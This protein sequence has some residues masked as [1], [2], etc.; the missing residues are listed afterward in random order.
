MGKFTI[1]TVLKKYIPLNCLMAL[2]SGSLFLNASYSYGQCTRVYDV[3]DAPSSQLTIEGVTV[4]YSQ[5][6]VG[7]GILGTNSGEQLS[8]TDFTTI[9]TSS[10][11]SVD[12]NSVANGF[13]SYLYQRLEFGQAIEVGNV[14]GFTDI[15][16]AAG[17]RE[18]AMVV[19]YNANTSTRVNPTY[20]N[21]ATNGVVLSMRNFD[22]GN[23]PGVPSATGTFNQ[24]II[25][26]ANGI[27]DIPND[28]PRGQFS[29]D[30][31]TSTI[32]SL[33]FV[34]G[35][36]SN[37][38][39]GAGTTQLSGISDLCIETTPT[40][41]ALLACPAA[42]SC[43]GTTITSGQ[44]SST[45][46]PLVINTVDNQVT[47]T[48]ITDGLGSDNNGVGYRLGTTT[49][50]TDRTYTLT[51]AQPI[52]QVNLELGFINN[53]AG[54]TA[55][56]DGEEE[57]T[58][59]ST[60]S[61]GTD[62]IGYTD[63]GL[64][65]SVTFS[66]CN[67][68]TRIFA[69]R[70]IDSKDPQS[71][72]DLSITS[73]SS[74]TQVTF[75]YDYIFNGGID[76]N[77]FGIII[78]E[79]C[80]ITVDPC[81]ALASGNL[82][83]DGDNVS[84]ICDIDDDNDGILDIIENARN[85][86]S[87]LDGVVDGSLEGALNVAW[88]ESTNTFS[89]NSTVGGT[90]WNTA[91]GSPD[92]WQGSFSLSGAGF[93]SGALNGVP[94][95]PDGQVFMA[96]YNGFTDE[97]TSTEIPESA[98]VEVGDVIRIE[99]IQVFGG[100]N[101][102]TPLNA[103]AR[104]RWTIDGVPYLA[105]LL[106]YNG[107]NPK[108]WE[109]DFIEFTATTT[110]PDIVLD[111]VPSSTNDGNYLAI[112]GIDVQNVTKQSCLPEADDDRDGIPNSL[113]LDSDG[114]GCPD[115]VE[116]GLPLSNADLVSASVT[117]GNGVDATANTTT[118]IAN[119]QLDI[120]GTDS[121]PEDGLNDSLDANGDGLP[122]YTSTYLQIALS[123][124]LDGCADFDNDGIGDLA[125]IDD[126]N[127]GIVDAEESPS[128][129]FTEAEAATIL[130]MTSGFAPQ[131]G[132]SLDLLFDGNTTLTF[133]FTN[134]QTVNVG[135][136]WFTL[137]LT[138]PIELETVVVSN[139]FATSGT[140]NLW[141]SHDNSNFVQLTSSA[142][143][144]S[145]ATPTT[146]ITFV[147]DQNAD[148][149]KYYQIRA[150]TAATTSN[151][152]AIAEI[153]VTVKLDTYVA[154]KSF[155]TSCTEDLD[156]DGELNHLDL[157][158]DGDG[159]PDLV[160]AGVPLSNGDIVSASVTNG[161]GTDAMANTT[162]TID[163][164][165]LDPSGTD[166]TPEDGLNDSVDTDGNGEPDYTS[167]YS[168]FALDGSTDACLDSDLDGVVD[169][170]DIDD[171]ND[172]ILDIDEGLSSM[173][174][175]PCQLNNIRLFT[176]FPFT[177][178]N[179]VQLS[180]ITDFT[181]TTSWPA[182]TS[183]GLSIPAGGTNVSPGNR[184]DN[185]SIVF[186]KPVT[187]SIFM[188]LN[189]THSDEIWDFFVDNGSLQ[190]LEEVNNGCLSVSGNR[191]T[192]SIA[193]GNG[194]S[195]LFEFVLD[196]ASRLDV[197]SVSGGTGT[198]FA[199]HDC[200]ESIVPESSEDTDNDGI[201]NHLDLDSDGDGCPDS[202]EAGLPLTNGD[203]GTADVE[204][205]SGGAVTSTVN[206]AN[207][208]LDPNATDS[209]PEDGLNDSVDTNGDGVPDYIS[210]YSLIALSNTLDGC[211]DF[212]NDGIGDLA[213]IDDDNDGIVDAE[214]SPSCF[215]SEA[216]FNAGDR[217]SLVT[218][219]TELAMNA[220]YNAPEEVVDGVVGTA[221]AQYAVRFNNQALSGQEIYKFEFLQAVAIDDIFIEYIN[222]NS[223]FS[224]AI[225]RIEGSNDN[226]NWTPLSNDITYITSSDP[227]PITGNS[228]SDQLEITQNRG[229]YK[230]YRL[231]GISGNIS[232]NGNSTEVNFV[233]DSFVASKYFKATCTEDLDSDGVLNHRDLDSD[234][235][236]CPDAEEAGVMPTTGIGNGNVENGDGTTN[237]IVSTANA[238]FTFISNAT[239]DSNSDGIL[240]S[241]DD[242][243]G[244][245][246]VDQITEYASTYSFVG[247]SSFLDA[248]LDTDNDDIIDLIDIDDDND[249]VVDAE[250]SPGCFYLEEEFNE[251]DR[252]T[253]VT[254]TTELNMIATY[255]APEELVDSDVGTAAANY[256]VQFVNAQ[257]LSGQEVYKFEFI[258]PIRV[259]DIFIEYVNTNSHFSNA[260]IR[261]EGSNNDMTWTALSA[262]VTYVTS[263]D[264]NPI[265]GNSRSD[266]LEITQ[267]Q[268]DY[269]YY[270]LFGI[271]GTISSNGLSS[272]VNFVFDDYIASKYPKGLCIEDADGDGIFNHLDLDSDG[273]GCP[274]AVEANVMPTTGIGT[275]A[276]ENGSGGMV[277]ST[278]SN[279]D[280]AQFTFDSTTNGG[281]DDT[282][283]DGL[284]DTIDSNDGATLPLDSKV[285]YTS[286]YEENALNVFIDACLDTDDDGIADIFDIDDDNDG[287]ID[288][289]EGLQCPS[290][291]ATCTEIDPIY[292]G[293]QWT[294]FNTT[295]NTAVGT[296][297]NHRG[298]TITVNY[299][300]DVRNLL[301]NAAI[302]DTS[303]HC[304]VPS[305]SGGT[306]F[307]QTFSGTNVVHRFVFSQPVLN[308]VF[309]IW[310]LGAGN[311]TN[312]AAG[313][314]VTYDFVNEVS[315]LKSNGF[316]ALYGPNNRSLA[317]GE[318]DG[319]IVV[320]GA[321]TVI[322]FVANKSENWSGLTLA[323]GEIVDPSSPCFELDTDDDGIPNHLDLD[324]DGDG[325]PDAVEANVLPTTARGQGTIENG[326]GG[327]VT[328]T[329]P[330]V[331]NAQFI[332]DQTTNSGNDDTNNDGLLD[333]IDS[334]GGAVLPLDGTTEYASFYDDYALNS[335]IDACIDTDNDDIT[336][337]FDIDDDNDGILD[338]VESPS[339]FFSEASITTGDRT[340][341]ITVT[342][343]I[344]LINT[345]YAYDNAVDGEIAN[346]AA[347]QVRFANVQAVTG[348]TIMQFE[349]P[350]ALE[351]S[352]IT[353][354][355]L[356]S[357][358]FLLN[359]VSAT[360]QGSNDGSSWTNLSTSEA[361]GQSETD[362]EVNAVISQNAGNYRFYR[363]QG[364]AGSTWS[365]GFISEV[366]FILNNFYALA[367]CDE[368]L[369]ND[370]ILNHLDLDSDGDGCPDAIEGDGDFEQSN[371]T[372]AT[373]TGLDVPNNG[374][375][376]AG[377]P[378][379]GYAGSTNMSVIANLVGNSGT[380]A[381]PNVDTDPN[382][383]TYGVPITGL[384]NLPNTQ[385]I[386]GSQDVIDDTS[387]CDIVPPTIAPN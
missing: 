291:N 197:D 35:V 94:A 22:W 322:Q 91:A 59:I 168:T 329:T 347:N 342:S 268:G 89:L 133:N 241:I 71:G 75:T 254:V 210:T 82:D 320:A 79:L 160:E 26:A 181:P 301:S 39:G 335:A 18:I 239:N 49:A 129:F 247:T 265:T 109:P 324:S 344:A 141:G 98:G 107:N 255:S 381:S 317:G 154:S 33:Y 209:T 178:S 163:N 303:Q 164:A 150:T 284:L 325:C 84:D 92:T 85:C 250:E 88:F 173:P 6:A 343:D 376:G 171:D 354:Q 339:C 104:F 121:S 385:G 314:T 105:N 372:D 16:G 55:L 44:L 190:I 345:S 224:N 237:N 112:D 249:G 364:D 42:V 309:Q 259:D 96:I 61:G 108:T 298:V 217:S 365:N 64:G 138:A 38:T 266:Q 177:L 40:I 326:T 158:S 330:N 277:T 198:I 366:T 258:Q 293:V 101:G 243:G 333:S 315:I 157:D 187:G 166:S 288:A 304:P 23:L 270:R 3:A 358:S 226:S 267:N 307:I 248:C 384:N 263:S 140:S 260:V 41:A 76:D 128:C 308:P 179:G 176:D 312:P 336:D 165:Q 262:D 193:G 31:G 48:N 65:T 167:A 119:A 7:G 151:T 192:G 45:T 14:F 19:G 279:V 162:T 103:E 236:G 28:D 144:Q 361:Y 156:N 145:N 338:I 78:E 244:T 321:T 296:V 66:N 294:S 116:A 30:F 204:N 32:T 8:G 234:G 148:A 161:N 125:D 13:V 228:R 289:D 97:A 170:F 206:T 305:V 58:N 251:G 15:D 36:A 318:G 205:G 386:G 216:E 280:N 180:L 355:L 252:R 2:F 93:W 83:T 271:S 142:N 9:E 127:D 327:A 346:T 360:V 377:Q 292:K 111:I 282:N 371:L 316:L 95:T 24:S 256:A 283:G 130:S 68:G 213:D 29:A 188:S 375:D 300:G 74:F 1:V 110:S 182:W 275:G 80:Y 240:D 20:D 21:I 368:D 221:V 328:T 225:V 52:A 72:G 194:G 17:N 287:I 12:D 362:L 10:S 382:S 261:V 302:E 276:L 143:T 203:L 351:I 238:Q 379:T 211:A 242:N 352:E 27:G 356:N 199:I 134:A 46:S 147:V 337:V 37:V 86:V 214:E 183:C 207:A 99:F 67:S 220:T 70:N 380:L 212:D 135:D 90:G 124:T 5:G 373:G 201:P 73:T 200:F 274:D 169:V 77:P 208:Q 269:K 229:D 63:N 174:T 34:W 172:G 341:T 232:Q 222:T 120:N 235:D 223:H 4:T 114:D 51:F 50:T 313:S 146:N 123:N 378:V 273:D 331:D 264:A 100:T 106:T 285:E 132:E 348:N 332:F 350:L 54:L 387:C 278:T 131:L 349:F 115:A 81:D 311:N 185:F 53:D 191:I 310:S 253:D 117:N 56:T 272:E 175:E 297:T 218:V 202:V 230:Y 118:T 139:R 69:E 367:L 290:A 357:N 186:D 286:M 149:Y 153:T 159:C 196:G 47:I 155:K 137:N 11:E 370:G 87:L 57:I 25:A 231:W 215:Y 195:A 299:E 233:F 353:F 363:L 359:G 334:N 219:T 184:D 281:A 136:N 246:T 113:D 152:L 126:D 245:G 62:T 306:N 102:I 383:S 340:S 60:N 295:T 319:S 257:T 122:D 43:T 374:L 227:N 369:D 189:V 323:V